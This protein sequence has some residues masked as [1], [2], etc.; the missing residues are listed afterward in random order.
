MDQKPP[1][2]RTLNISPPSAKKPVRQNR[3]RRQT[4]R[5]ATELRLLANNIKEIIHDISFQRA[6][7]DQR[8]NT[9]RRSYVGISRSAT[10][11]DNQ[12]RYSRRNIVSAYY[13]EN[14][15]GNG[16]TR[17]SGMQMMDRVAT[18]DRY[19]RPLINETGDKTSKRQSCPWDLSYFG[20]HEDRSL[21]ILATELQHLREVRQKEV[22]NLLEVNNKLQHDLFEADREINVLQQKNMTSDKRLH[23]MLEVY[24]RIRGNLKM[25]LGKVRDLEILGSKLST[26]INSDDESRLVCAAKSACFHIFITYCLILF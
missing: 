23:A 19:D 21:Q 4:S 17:E 8:D 11:Y 12:W 20:Q 26:P 1:R 6:T 7:E 2:P 10:S 16:V 5:N 24:E 18:G 3:Q 25:C 22:G 15:D 14:R 9:S 13:G